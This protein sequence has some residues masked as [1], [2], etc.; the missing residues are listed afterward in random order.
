MVAVVAMLLVLVLAVPAQAQSLPSVASGHRPG[1]DILYAP[2]AAAPQLENTGPWTAQP[3]LV[4]GTSAYRDGE[5][6]YQ[7]FL[8]DDHGAQGVRDPEDPF[9]LEDFAFSPKHGTLTYP[10]HEAYAN[11][12]ADFVELRVKPLADATGFR[13]TF[14]TLIEP[15][16]TAFTIALGSSDS[17][18]DWPHGAG[19]SSP[20]DLFLTVHGDTAELIDAQSG[21]AP[22]APAP[23]ASVDVTRRQVD[24][25]VPHEA[26]DPGTGSVRIA[27]GAG[28][29]DTEEGGYLTPQAAASEDRPGGAAAGDPPPALFNMAF[30]FDE[31]MPETANPATNTIAEGSVLAGADGAFWRERAQADALQEGDVSD[32]FAEVDFGMLEAG[33]R[34]DSGIPA[35]G[36]MNRI[37]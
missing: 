14:N 20:A 33:T 22:D 11:N 26:W 25:R 9:S 2:P 3:I 27:A 23:T 28:L 30:R 19:V 29:W 8:Y 17:P 16:R 24:V 35:T 18:V 1:P 32:F 34:D 12:A 21:A 10:T 6:L 15:E 13:V 37:L 4:S 7:D 5:F 36:A 31:P